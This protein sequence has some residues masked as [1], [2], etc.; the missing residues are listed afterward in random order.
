MNNKSQQIA[1]FSMFLAFGLI[2]QA[3]EAM[4][5]PSIPI[6]GIKLGLA[7]LVTLVML[8]Y[9]SPALVLAQVIARLAL[10]SLILGSFLAPAFY[11]S[12][13]G[14]LLSFLVMIMLFKTLY[15]KISLVGLSLAGAVFHNIGQL[16]VAFWL[17][18]TTAVY[19]QLPLLL[20]ASIPMGLI[21]G[22]AANYSMKR[23]YEI[24]GLD[25]LL[26]KGA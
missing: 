17:V 20:I 26:L 1:L 23:L 15:P 21:I 13:A 19:L 7:N 9:F 8:F 24:D 16:T 3:V 6:P 12:A 4:Y 14:A 22:I 11:F 2:L 5:L 18:K 10:A 25:R